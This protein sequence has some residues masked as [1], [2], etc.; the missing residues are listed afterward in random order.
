[1]RHTYCCESCLC[2]FQMSKL[3]KHCP[4]CGKT[5]SLIPAAQHYPFRSFQFIDVYRV[6]CDIPT[7]EEK[8]QEEFLDF[9]IG[10]PLKD[11]MNWL[12]L[13]YPS[14]DEIID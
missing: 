6:L 11:I 3:P 14:I 5:H 12:R 7:E 8:I 2:V 10:T 13:R 9:P 4:H 1:M